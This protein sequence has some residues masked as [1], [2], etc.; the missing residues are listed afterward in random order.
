MFYVGIDVGGTKTAYGLFDENRRLID[1]CKQPSDSSLAADVFFEGLVHAVHDLLRRNAL[2]IGDLAGVG[3]GL[4]SFIEYD[5]GY[6][7]KTSNLTKL[8]DFAARDDLQRRLGADVR[9]VLDNDAHVAALAEHRY[10]AG[11]GFRHM[12]YCPVSTGISSALI[13]E[14]KLFRGSYGFAGESGHQIITPGAGLMCGCENR[15]CFMSYV[16][17]SMIVRHIQGWIASGESTVMTALAGSAQAITAE[18]V[19]AGYDRGDAMAIRAVEQMAAYMAVWLYNLYLTLN[20][21]CFVFG[22][23]LMA[24]GDRLFSRVRAQFDAYN[25]NDYPVFFKPAELTQDCGIIGAAELLF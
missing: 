23:G 4:P 8:K 15:G 14:G 20:I 17:G 21:N 6:I 18:H 13:I 5:R 7:L 16:S 9:I 11:R 3:V 25:A 2:T 24:F 22:G 12:L 1:K 10:G 19:L